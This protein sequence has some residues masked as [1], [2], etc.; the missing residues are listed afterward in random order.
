[1]ISQ[2]FYNKP[3]IELINKLI[4]FIGYDSLYHNKIIYVSEME[5]NNVLQ[6]FNNIIDEI[7]DNYIPC[8]KKYCD[9]LTIKKCIS[10]TRQHLKTVNYDMIS[11]I[12]YINNKRERGYRIVPLN[13]KKF[14]KNKMEIEVR[15]D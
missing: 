2:L 4:M 14:I 6:L 9:S 10:I 3:E 13:Q 8:K 12:Y 1:M 15:F 7:K 11:K 5:K